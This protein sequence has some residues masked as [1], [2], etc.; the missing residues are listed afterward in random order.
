GCKRLRWRLQTFAVKIG[1]LG[2]GFYRLILGQSRVGEGRR[3]QCLIVVPP[4]AL[5]LS[6]E[7]SRRPWYQ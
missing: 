1:K 5:R 3:C 7:P 4:V 2:V 6:D